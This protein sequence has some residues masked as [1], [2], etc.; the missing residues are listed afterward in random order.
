MQISNPIETHGYFWLPESPDN[1]VWGILR[2]SEA[3][4][5]SLEIFGTF[6]DPFLE[7]Q[8]GKLHILGL[9]DRHVGPVTLCDCIP[10]EVTT[11]ENAGLLTKSKIHVG[12]AEVPSE[13]V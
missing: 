8:P 11:T 13:R 7:L 9:I 12:R 1:K 2:I 6:H 4:D 10:I 5:S 3:G